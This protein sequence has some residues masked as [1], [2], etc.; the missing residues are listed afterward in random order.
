MLKVFRNIRRAL[1]NQGQTGRY[2]KYALGE[3]ILVVIGILIA[4]QINK[5]NENS[6]S[7]K[8]IYNYF[9]KMLVEMR[10]NKGVLKSVQEV[11]LKFYEDVDRI[12]RI[13]AEKNPDSIP[14]LNSILGSLTVAGDIQVSF[15][16]M[17]EFYEQ[18]L[19]VAI[20]NDSLKIY[21]NGLLDMRSLRNQVSQWAIDSYLNNIEPFYLKH[22]NYS[23]TA[24]NGSK[25]GYVLAGPDT[26]F[27]ELMNSMEFW[28][29]I[30]LK[31]EANNYSARIL[32][33]TLY[34]LEKVSV[35]LEKELKNPA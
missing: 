11:N 29:V 6:K 10:H 9:D 25:K 3:I 32:E 31:Q 28:N 19:Q 27:E 13:T 14:V 7:Q 4:L 23:K 2:L 18:D 22:I 12:A 8:R 17:D 16:V 26:N 21:L 34:M 15:P 5:W 20:T 33:R 1:L 35:F 24:T 30:T